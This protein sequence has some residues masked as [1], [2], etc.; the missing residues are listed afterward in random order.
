M[1]FLLALVAVTIRL[2]YGLYCKRYF[3][4]CHCNWIYHKSHG[5]EMFS[6]VSWNLIG[7]VASVTKEQG[8]NIVLNIFLVHLLMQHGALLIGTKCVKWFC[9]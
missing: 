4:D 7:S 9:K 8:I 3:T 2:V 5:A 1:L 6:F